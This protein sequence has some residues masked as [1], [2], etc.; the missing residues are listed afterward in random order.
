MYCMDLWSTP[1]EVW[2]STMMYPHQIGRSL[3]PNSWKSTLGQGGV[4]G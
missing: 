1:I 4:S 3:P 2:G